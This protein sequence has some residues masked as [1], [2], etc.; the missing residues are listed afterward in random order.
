MGADSIAL[1]RQTAT[2]GVWTIGARL[3]AKGVDF[4]SLIVLARFLGPGDFGLV[5]MAMT[6]IFIIEAVFELPLWSALTRVPD[7]TPRMYGTA[8][9]LSALRGLAIGVILASASWPMAHFYNEPRLIPLVIALAMAPILRGLMSA[10]MVQFAR[11][12]DF[13]RQAFLDVTSKVIA[14][15]AA[16]TLAV[17]TKS[18]WSIALG[19]ILTPT[20]LMVGSYILAPMRPRLT[21]KDWPLFADMVSWNVLSQILLAVN[22]QI[23]RFILPRFV[24]TVSFGRYAMANDL[25]AIPTQVLVSPLGFPLN[26]AFVTSNERG[27]LKNTY[28]KAMGAIAILMFPIYSFMGL[29]SRPLIDLFLGSKWE[30]AAFLL[31][32]LAL[33]S[34]IQ[35]AAAPM[36]PLAISLNQSRLI[37]FRSLTQCLVLVP[38]VIAGVWLFGVPGAIFAVCVEACLIMFMTMLTVRLLVAASIREQITALAGPV[39]ISAIAGTM[40]YCATLFIVIGGNPLLLALQIAVVGLFYLA[41]YAGGIYLISRWVKSTAGAEQMIISIGLNTLAKFRRSASGN[42]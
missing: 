36:P 29:V 2:A 35:A 13:R 23:G 1:S 34:F 17:L 25:A 22:W 40:L 37:T 16:V 14:G 33:S 38:L 20:V 10:R 30:G 41:V 21:L 26:V 39:A 24:D 18:Y 19:T 11:Q 7:P 9:T 42:K 8:F 31:S 5:A 32:G 28:L 4:A 3:V 27:D 12:M 15:T 6:L